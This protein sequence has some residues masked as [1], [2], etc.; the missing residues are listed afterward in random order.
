MRKAVRVGGF[1]FDVNIDSPNKETIEAMIEAERT[2][3][4]PKVKAYS[5]DEAFE[6]LD[7][8]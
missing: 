7:N 4:D 3:R 2:V 1:P 6:E 8:E 5:V